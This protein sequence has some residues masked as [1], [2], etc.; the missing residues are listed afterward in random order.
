MAPLALPIP[1]GL[2]ITRTYHARIVSS[3]EYD[4][5]HEKSVS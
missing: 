4:H 1:H 3:F 2:D 5:L